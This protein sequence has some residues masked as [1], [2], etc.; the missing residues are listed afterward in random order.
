MAQGGEPSTIDVLLALTRRL[1]GNISLDDALR[2]VTDA[3]LQLLP[4][5]HAS[6]RVLNRRRTELLCGAR[7]G[8]GAESGPLPLRRGEGVSGWVAEHGEPLR[9]G[10]VGQD[11][12]FKVTDHQGFQ[13]RSMLV[14]PLIAAGQ[15]VGVLGLTA[16][17][18]EVFS[19]DDET[20][21]MLLANCAVP[22]IEK[23]R[24][25]RLRQQ[26]EKKALTDSQTTAYSQRYLFPRLRQEIG[27]A[28][29][30]ARPLSILLLDLDD[31]KEVNDE[32]GH[33]IGD[34][35][36]RAFSKRVLSCVR[37]SDVLVRRGGDEFVLVMPDTDADRAADVAERVRAEVAE[38]EIA[39]DEIRVS[40]TASLGV[41]TLR[42]DET[43]K[44]LERRADLA[45]YTAKRRGRNR[46]VLAPA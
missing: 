27:R 44:D 14:V 29:R 42:E 4:G 22:T 19:A 10:D 45:M 41:A 40:L 25:R 11:P 16:P 6:V 17:E 2:A 3:A 35:V 34:A 39:G 36:L 31:F 9:L 46:V 23:A 20:L 38:K 8:R 1:V 43:A 30:H 26:A 12:R 28:R 7:S 37:T 15:V 21:A 24:L 5:E 13:I 18:P 32:H 33:G